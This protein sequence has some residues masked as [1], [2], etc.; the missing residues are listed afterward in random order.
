MY[1]AEH[2]GSLLRP[3]ELLQARAAYAQGQLSLRGL[4]AEEDRAIAAALEKQRQFGIDIL[5]D[6]EFRRG[7]WLTDMA[8]AVEGFV[9]DKVMLDWKGPGRRLRRQ[10]RQCRRRK[11]AE[12]PQDDRH[13]L[14]FLKKSAGGPF[15]IT[16]PA[17]SN[18]MLASYK[19]GISDR[20]YPTHAD[21]LRDLVDIVRDEIRW[22]RL[23][24][25]TLHPARRSLL[26]ALYR[27]ARPRTP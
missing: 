9:P 25:V 7:S 10:H 5:S 20:F 26:F 16:L 13:E 15:K 22:L 2:V 8:D 14:P 17:P 21:L 12:A 1:R 23:R 3:P 4:R 18:F 19:K 6:G 24:G 27:S 11:I